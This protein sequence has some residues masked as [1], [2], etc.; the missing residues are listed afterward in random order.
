[1]LVSCFID[2]TCQYSFRAFRWLTRLQHPAGLD[3]RWATFSLKEANRDAGTPSPFDDPQISSLS[4]LA[5]AL[6]HAA[7]GTGSSRYHELVFEAMHADRRRL[8]EAALL[9]LAGEAGVDVE[10]FNQQRGRWLEAVAAEHRA[11]AREFDVFGTPTLVVG[12]HAA[13]F[14]KLSEIPAPEQDAELWRSLHNLACCHPELIEIKRS[15]TGN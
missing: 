4:V 7:R 13:V 12:D 2:Y 15:R 11:G 6:G 3:V 1:M 9:E 8:H 14:L 5:L 10:Q